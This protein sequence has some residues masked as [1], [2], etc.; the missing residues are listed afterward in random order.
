MSPSV[1]KPA[2]DTSG[3]ATLESVVRGALPVAKLADVMSLAA[4][5]CP[6]ASE[7]FCDHERVYNVA[8]D[9]RAPKHCV[10]LRHHL[11]NRGLPAW[12]RYSLMHY[13]IPD[14]RAP[15]PV[16]RRP[17]QTVL[18]SVEAPAIVDL[19]GC[20]LVHEY[21]RRGTRLR[22]RSG[23]VL[24]LYVAEKLSVPGDPESAVRVEPGA[25]GGENN[26]AIAE[27]RSDEGASAEELLLFMS[28]LA[29][30]GVVIREGN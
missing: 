2:R 28:H 8:A 25:E 18:A 20:V 30:A 5:L 23:L 16:E 22:S 3:V 17:V 13:G 15:F 1:A 11:D 27:V 9:M 12:A 29:T 26:F 10:R 24:D 19:M 21:V 7:A 14:R 4:L 6:D